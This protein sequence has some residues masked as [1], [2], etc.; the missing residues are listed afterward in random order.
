VEKEK[1]RYVGPNYTE[2]YKKIAE[3]QKSVTCLALE[4]PEAVHDDVSRRWQEL[5][6][7]IEKICPQG[8]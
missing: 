5:K 7:E 8:K 6:T 3:V 4:L 1:T 2:L